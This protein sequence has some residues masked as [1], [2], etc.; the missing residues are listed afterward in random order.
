MVAFRLSC[1]PVLRQLWLVNI[2]LQLYPAVFVPKLSMQ[3]DMWI[4]CRDRMESA[5][6]DSVLST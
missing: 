6:W 2:R 4:N 1:S 3:N 5:K